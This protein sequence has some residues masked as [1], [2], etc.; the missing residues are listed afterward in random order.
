MEEIEELRLEVKRLDERLLAMEVKL[1]QFDE[2]T[3]VIQPRHTL[4]PFDRMGDVVDG[5]F[6]SSD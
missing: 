3:K 4:H 1:Q 5:V 6:E 2:R